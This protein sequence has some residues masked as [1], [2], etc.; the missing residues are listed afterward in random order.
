[1]TNARREILDHIGDRDVKYVSVILNGISIDGTLPEV[2]PRL[3][4]EYV[5]GYGSLYLRGTIWYTDGTWSTR[6]EYDGA[7][8]WCHIS[9]P[10]CPIDD[11]EIENATFSVACA[12]VLEY[13]NAPKP[14]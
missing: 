12:P 10:P 6:R 4:E 14:T 13:V 11:P 9:R 2:L 5:E 3:D 1:M 7:E 8:W